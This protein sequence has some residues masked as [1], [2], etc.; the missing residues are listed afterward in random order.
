MK[1]LVYIGNDYHVLNA[2]GVQ[3]L[4]DGITSTAGVAVWRLREKI[5]PLRLYI[6]GGWNGLY[7]ADKYGNMEV[8]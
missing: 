6:H 1:Y 2:E 3:A 4:L 8:I 5:E 7:L